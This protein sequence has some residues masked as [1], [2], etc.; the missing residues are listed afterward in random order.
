M[1]IRVH[2][3]RW[4]VQLEHSVSPELGTRAREVEE[5]GGGRGGCQSR[6]CGKKTSTGEGRGHATSCEGTVLK[7]EVV[8]PVWAG[9]PTLYC[10]PSFRKGCPLAH[11]WGEIKMI[12]WSLRSGRGVSAEQAILDL[13]INTHTYKSKW[14]IIAETSIKQEKSHTH[15]QI[16]PHIGHPPALSFPPFL[17]LPGDPAGVVPGGEMRG[18]RGCIER[19]SLYKKSGIQRTFLQFSPPRMFI[20][21]TPLPNL[22][23]LAASPLSDLR[24][25]LR[26]SLVLCSVLHCKKQRLFV[27]TPWDLATCQLC[28]QVRVR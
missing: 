7:R 10:V 24:P 5:K 18:V 15:T 27:S 23:N 19:I 9:Y 21:Y 13:S 16:L 12:D 28:K 1:G 3:G 22:P 8:N 6:P 26:L 14:C 11:V 2:A 4:A 25:P 20:R 17:H